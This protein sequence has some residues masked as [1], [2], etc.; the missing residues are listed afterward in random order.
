LLA[1]PNH[2]GS[3]GEVCESFE[4]CQAG[5][6]R[7]EDDGCGGDPNNISL[8]N[9]VLYQAVEVQLMTGGMAISPETRNADIIQNRDAVLRASV[10]LET[11][12]S[13]RAISLRLVLRNDDDETILF[14]RRTVNAS[15]T[16]GDL[17]STFLI[18]VPA[19]LIGPNTSYV[20]SLADCEDAASA[21][22]VGDIAWP[23]D[24]AI[25][26][27][28]A[29][30]VGRVK[31]VFLPLVHDNLTPD[32]TDAAL[33]SYA[34]GVMAQYPIEGVDYRAVPAIES[35]FTGINFDWGRML[36]ETVFAKRRDDA[37]AADEYYYALVK[38]TERLGQ[39]CQGGCTAG[40]GY[41]TSGATAMNVPYRTA[42]GLG[43]NEEVSW[44][45]L[46]HELG[47]N[48]GRD[49]APCGGVNDDKNYPYE[50]ASIG[51]YGMSIAD[52]ALL[53][54]SKYVDFMSYCSPT[55]ISDY[56][57]QAL[58]ERV[59]AVN[60]DSNQRAKTVGV[61]R[62]WWSL[63]STSSGRRWSSPRTTEGALDDPLA[64]FVYDQNLNPLA[65][66]ELGKIPLSGGGA[67]VLLVPPP[68]QGWYAVGIAGETPFPY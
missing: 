36:D 59:A 19:A 50:G 67:F 48:H 52:H 13:P 1:D 8:T 25:A 35:G 26:A 16:Q 43:F 2:C 55:W 28:G 57:F 63:L 38:P 44:S 15:S 11:G 31:L 58:A 34:A 10:E 45:T 62:S 7:F 23:R 66:V 4:A 29:R 12:T 53:E 18:D 68:E 46:P 64:G 5:K 60:E 14:H 40:I 49:H 37:P 56:T 17:G 30:K 33:A 6:C 3:C 27:L 51:S 65:E 54:P 47:H 42:L 9:V 21:G 61:Q 20:V 32:T 39:Y 22:S 41:L 24:G